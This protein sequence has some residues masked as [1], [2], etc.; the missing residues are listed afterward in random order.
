M[1]DII[2]RELADL[3]EPLRVAEWRARIEAALF[4]S[5]KPLP[6]ERLA[7]LVGQNAN[8]S[9]LIDDIAA[10]LD[11]EGRPW[12]LAS[13][14]GGW[15]LQTRPAYAAAIRLALGGAEDADGVVERSALSRG[16]TLALAAVAYHQPIT[17]DE[18]EK[19]FGVR[20]SRDVLSAL[21]RRGWISNSLTAPRMGAPRAYMTTHGFLEAFG[22]ETLDDLPP[23]EEF[24]AGA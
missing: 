12:S 21:V 8:V 18:I 13:Q 22:L 10:R 4:A 14:R 15:V 1:P 11:R 17:R 2:D 16:E 3:P 19:L 23:V 7:S 5:P 20:I 9:D 6:A 24:A